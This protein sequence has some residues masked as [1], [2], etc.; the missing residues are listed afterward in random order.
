MSKKW[1]GIMAVIVLTGI[2]LF[3][4]L[5][6]G[7]EDNNQIILRYQ[8]VP[9]I[10]GVLSDNSLPDFDLEDTSVT[11][12]TVA[13][14]ELNRDNVDAYLFT[15]EHFDVLSENKYSQML[16][17]NGVPNFFIDP[18]KEVMPFY[19]ENLLYRDV[20]EA[21]NQAYIEGFAVLEDETKTWAIAESYQ[22]ATEEL[23]TSAYQSLL[24]V[25]QT[26]K[27]QVFLKQ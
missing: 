23:K 18:K 26:R 17:E 15:K 10:I 7:T 6:N 25:L 5:T 8:G 3:V 20:P 14:D 13:L 21:D 1:I 22:D 24:K 11:F 12:Q 4:V 19:L 2:T 9:L 27:E 16:S